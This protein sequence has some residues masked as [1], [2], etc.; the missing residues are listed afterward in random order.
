MASNFCFFKKKK[1]TIFLFKLLCFSMQSFV[2][3]QKVVQKACA[4]VFNI[5]FLTTKY[6]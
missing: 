2:K 4:K 5:H 6:I 1:I 3:E